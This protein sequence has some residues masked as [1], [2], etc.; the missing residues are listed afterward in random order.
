[1][2]ED[3]NLKETFIHIAD[4]PLEMDFEIVKTR[5]QKFGLVPAIRREKY[6]ADRDLGY[7]PCFNDWVA[8]RMTLNKAIP[9][10][11]LTGTVRMFVKYQGEEETCRVCNV[12]G[13]KQYACSAIS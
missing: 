6:S 7:F 8:V 11:I 5:L 1:M 10:Y 12:A 13:H 9:S 2:I 4:E 3:L